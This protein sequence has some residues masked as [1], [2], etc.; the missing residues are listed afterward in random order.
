MTTCVHQYPAHSHL[1][2]NLPNSQAAASMVLTAIVVFILCCERFK[3]HDQDLMGRYAVMGVALQ[4]V[5]GYSGDDKT[6]MQYFLGHVYNLVMAAAAILLTRTFVAPV[7]TGEM[8]RGALASALEGL[9]KCVRETTSALATDAQ[10]EEEAEQAKES[11]AGPPLSQEAVDRIYS[12]SQ[13]VE[14][15]L[16]VRLGC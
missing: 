16:T 15:A 8:C 13:S 2:N 12:A 14:K 6:P 5:G 10:G 9:G 7:T 4:M 1:F 11:E 3:R